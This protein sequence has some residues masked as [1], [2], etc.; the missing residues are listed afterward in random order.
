MD[1]IM[2]EVWGEDTF[3]RE[4]YLVGT[5]ETREKANKALKASERSVLHQCE[6][7]RDTYWIVELTPKRK[8]ERDEWMSEREEQHR[9]K[10]DFDYAR[11]CELVCRLNSRLLETVEQDMKGNI[12]EKEVKLMEKNEKVDDCYNFLS[13]QYIR[14]VKD[15]GCCLVYVE[16][17]FKDEGKMSSSCFVGTPNQIRRQFSFKKGEKFVCGIV[18]K[19]IIDFFR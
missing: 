16:I 19:M 11:L 2:Y 7:L 10:S 5:Y 17:E 12:T 8:R 4:N 9:R 13:L 1:K 6:E 15:G 18:D 3:A 14:G